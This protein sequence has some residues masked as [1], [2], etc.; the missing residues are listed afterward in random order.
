MKD[1]IKIPEPIHDD[2]RI[3]IPKIETTQCSKCL[4]TY[5]VSNMIHVC[6]TGWRLCAICGLSLEKKKQKQRIVGHYTFVQIADKKSFKL[7]DKKI[8]WN[9]VFNLVKQFKR[10]T[11]ND[12]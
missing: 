3:K 1:K 12:S 4:S 9:C 2:S 11:K 7:W 5:V 8:C 10:K 6:N